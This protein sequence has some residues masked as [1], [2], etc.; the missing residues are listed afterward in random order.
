MLLGLTAGVGLTA[1][2]QDAAIDREHQ[3]KATFLYHFTGYVEWPE[4]AFSESQQAVVIGILG[5]APL[6]GP[7][8]EISNSKTSGRT[9]ELIRFTSIDAVEPCHILFIARGV[10]R[11]HELA[12][13]ERLSGQ[14]V[15]IVGETP[16][17]AERGG[18]VN[19]VTEDDHVRIEVNHASARQRKL[20]ISSKVLALARLIEQQ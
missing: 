8:S 9:I 7:L 16:G 6:H 17:F 20:K 15:L 2:G 4:T 12:A 1:R 19:F 5:E 3:V 13:I 14:S 11:E 18:A 10:P